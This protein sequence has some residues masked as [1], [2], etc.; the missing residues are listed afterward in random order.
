MTVTFEGCYE[1]RAAINGECKAKW[2]GPTQNRS[3]PMS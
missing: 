2:S 3:Y 1:A